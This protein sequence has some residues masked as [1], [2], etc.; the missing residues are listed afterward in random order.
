MLVWKF[1]LLAEI[2]SKH[3]ENAGLHINHI[4]E[5]AVRGEKRR[6]WEKPDRGGAAEVAYECTCS[7]RVSGNPL[8]VRRLLRT[9][10]SEP[11]YRPKCLC[12]A[13]SDQPLGFAVGFFFCAE[14]ENGLYILQTIMN[15]SQ[16]WYIAVGYSSRKRWRMI[17]SHYRHA[18]P[19]I[20]CTSKITDTA[21]GGG[22]FCVTCTWWAWE[23]RLVMYLPR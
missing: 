15:A 8:R 1:L 14:T 21:I 19:N 3:R 17:Q 12:F 18:Q 7:A 10:S 23:I 13:S 16:Q 4:K 6:K 9:R 5:M 20:K 22:T 2:R 11:L